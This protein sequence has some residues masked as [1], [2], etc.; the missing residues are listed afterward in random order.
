[1]SL[2]T[3]FPG[4]TLKVT[5]KLKMPEKSILTG[6]LPELCCDEAKKAIQEATQQCTEN[7]SQSQ[8]GTTLLDS[9]PAISDARSPPSVNQCTSVNQ[10]ILADNLAPPGIK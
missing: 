9:L 10:V 6:Q 3:E 2:N 4:L 1:M 5:H 7:T 8:S